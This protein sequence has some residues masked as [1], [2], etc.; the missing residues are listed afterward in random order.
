MKNIDF[1]YFLLFKDAEQ[2]LYDRTISI[3]NEN[4]RLRKTLQD[5][6]KRIQALNES[7]QQLE[8]EQIYFV[9]QLRLAADLK[10]IRL[11]KIHSAITNNSTRST[12][13]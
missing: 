5:L 13:H 1:F 6:L 10:R 7:K 11:D 3:Q 4:Y 8:E 9:R 12:P 2:F